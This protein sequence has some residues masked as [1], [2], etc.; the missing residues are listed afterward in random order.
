MFAVSRGELVVVA[1][2]F[3]LVWGAGALPRV[4]ERLAERFRGRRGG[5][6]G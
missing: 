4:G 6:G 5:D 1:F 2:I 3:A